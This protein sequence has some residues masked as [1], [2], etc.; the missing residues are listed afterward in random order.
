MGYK[1]ILVHLDASPRSAV[2]LR[3]AVSLARA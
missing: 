3:V 1:D 2:R